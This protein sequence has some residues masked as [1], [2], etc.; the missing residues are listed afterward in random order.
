VTTTSLFAFISMPGPPEMLFLAMIAL[1][2]FGKDLPH[3]L[4]EWGKTFNEFRR[5]LNSV[6][7]EL[8]DAIY[9]EPERPRLQYHPQFQKREETQ[10]AA[11]PAATNGESAGDSRPPLAASEPGAGPP[12]MPTD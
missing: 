2:I 1:L 5:H 6:K 11:T 8:N 4:R 7:S 3:V 12:D 9:A 10:P